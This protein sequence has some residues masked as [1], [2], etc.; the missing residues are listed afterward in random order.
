MGD[1]LLYKLWLTPHHHVNE[2]MSHNSMLSY[3]K[4]YTHDKRHCYTRHTPL[5]TEHLHPYLGNTFFISE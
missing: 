2:V 1:M 3:V 4:S 5:N